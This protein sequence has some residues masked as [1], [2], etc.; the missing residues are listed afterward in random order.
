MTNAGKVFISYSRDDADQ[1][2]L[3]GSALRSNGLGVWWD[4]NLLAGERWQQELDD[5]LTKAEAIIVLW[6]ENSVRSNWVL[7][8]ASIAKRLDK[9][10]NVKIE[11]T[12]LPKPFE[13]IQ[14]GDLTAWCRKGLQARDND[15]DFRALVESIAHVRRKRANAT[16]M[17]PL[18][19]CVIGTLIIIGLLLGAAGAIFIEWSRLHN[20]AS[21]CAADSKTT[22]PP[23]LEVP[24]SYP[25]VIPYKP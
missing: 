16:K 22:A 5:Q 23:V 18:R 2:N 21:I 17:V 25:S 1:A 6:S 11:D 24:R 3:V 10:V 20:A 4:E 19:S 8:E 14:Y 12:N 9:L 15:P 13:N 7:F